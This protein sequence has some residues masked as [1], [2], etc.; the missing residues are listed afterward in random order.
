[1]NYDDSFLT[2]VMVTKSCVLICRRKFF[3][4]TQIQVNMPDR[5]TGMN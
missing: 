3:L 4:I 2:F 5:V 1:M